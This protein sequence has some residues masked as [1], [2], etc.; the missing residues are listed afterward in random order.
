MEI[1]DI[2]VSLERLDDVRGGLKL[3]VTS[4]G[5][6]VGDNSAFSEASSWGVG[7]KTSSGVTQIAPQKLTQSAS[8]DAA[9]LDLRQIT[10]DHS[11]VGFPFLAL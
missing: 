7:N 5:L 6:Q 8:V 9:E 3:D 10:V 4:V 2:S 1:R 11:V